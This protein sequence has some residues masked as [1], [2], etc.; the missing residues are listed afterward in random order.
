MTNPALSGEPGPGG[1]CRVCGSKLPP[2]SLRCAQCGAT[3]GERNRCPHC[4]AVADVEPSGTLRWR[5]KAC[6]GPRVPVEDA[7]V[8]RTGREIPLLER[9]QRARMRAAGFRA[10]AGVV[11]GF[12]VIS[13]LVSL[14]V[15]ALVTPGVVG[16]IGTLVVTAV[17][18]ILAFF[19]WRRG[20]AHARELEQLLDQAWTLVAS[21][22]LASVGD[23]LTAADL[24]KAMRL[25][26]AQAE[27]LL[28]ELG[29]TDFVH[30]RVTDGGDVVYSSRPPE[31]ARLE[32]PAAEHPADAEAE[33]SHP[34]QPETSPARTQRSG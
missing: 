14:L 4:H 8:V 21:D 23:G 29:A 16:T 31:R 19:A 25:E 15:M 11:A 26:E 7:L 6:G 28:A 34:H 13:L 18:F 10:A 5:C 27:A 3:Y 2:S 24:A 20:R 32:E 17:P 9:A 12:G 33:L 1:T 22:V 30:A